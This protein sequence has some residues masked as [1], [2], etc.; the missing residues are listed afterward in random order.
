MD[1]DKRT[2]GVGVGN[3]D[4]IYT[5]QAILWEPFYCGRLETLSDVYHDSPIER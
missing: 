4:C 2:V 5:S 3:E 1:D